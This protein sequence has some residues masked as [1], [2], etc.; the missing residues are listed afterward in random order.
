MNT[1]S[2]SLFVHE[3]ID[4]RPLGRMQ[5]WAI[6]LC[7]LVAVLDGFDTQTI[8]ML[9][10]AMSAELGIPV[11]SFGPIFSAGLVG[12]LIGAVTL[13]PLADRHGRKTMI[14]LSSVL[15]GSLSLATAYATSFDQLLILRL[16]TGV[17]LGGALPNAISLA[18]E[19]APKRHARTTV[20]TLMCGMPLGAVLGGLVSSALLPVHG[21]HSVFVV[22][23]VLPLAVALLAAAFMP[24]SA[25]FLIARGG[26]AGRVAAI[27]RRI[28]PELGASQV[29]RAPQ[30]PRGGVPVRELFTGGRAAETVLLWIPY[31]LNLVVLY[32][33][34]SWMPALLIGAQH[35]ASVGITA[36]SLFSIGGVAGSIAQGPLMNRFG[37]RRVLLCEL[38]AYAALA[39][40]LANWSASFAT[41][42]TVS[43]LIGIAVQGAQAGLNALA[44]EIYPTHMRATGVG[45]A[46]GMGRIGSI[47]GPLLGGVMLGL[48]WD[49]AH[50]FLAGIVP[51]LVAA[52]AIAGN[53]K[54]RA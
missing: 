51:A 5:C 43:L 30:A 15:F 23:G 1:S 19:Y 10:P 46:I 38:L 31:F 40:V 47:C 36:I 7:I 49:V 50:I 39:V 37:A 53:R 24:E 21:W 33:I 2:P 45:C 52:I 17:G 26:D 16:L 9:A 54:T 29:Y 41:V 35:P 12:M 25:R 22:G 42:A 32:F 27:M 13:G 11:R 28:A 8:G 20:A 18:S 4:S 3:V 14:V 34:V 6:G 44:A 48:Q